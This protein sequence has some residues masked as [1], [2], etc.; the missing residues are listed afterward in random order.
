MKLKVRDGM[1]IS[2]D[3]PSGIL[4][5]RASQIPSQSSETLSARG[6]QTVDAGPGCVDLEKVSCAPVSIGVQHNADGV[7]TCQIAVASHGVDGDVAR[8][9]IFTCKTK[10][11]PVVGDDYLDLGFIRCRLSRFWRLLREFHYWRISP[12]RFVQ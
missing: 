11:D 1:T 4:A 2:A 6:N 8:V 9:R 3:Q 10:I 5:V 12:S 7:I